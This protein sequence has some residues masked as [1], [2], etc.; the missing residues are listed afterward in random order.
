M[1]N[2]AILADVADPASAPAPADGAG[3]RKP[4][5]LP[6]GGVVY[7]GYCDAAGRS[8]GDLTAGRV[9]AEEPYLA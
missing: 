3:K 4:K 6:P 8:L 1:L 2:F 7:S 5:G 9:S